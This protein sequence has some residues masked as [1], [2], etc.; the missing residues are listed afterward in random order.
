[1][2]VIISV[3][4]LSLMIS[5]IGGA[6]HLGIRA[7]ERDSSITDRYQ[8]HRILVDQLSQE[9]RSAYLNE[10]NRNIVFQGTS[11]EV[12]FF[13]TTAGLDG[14][15]SP[16]GIRA[17]AYTAKEGEGLLV[18][19]GQ[20]GLPPG[21]ESFTKGT[22]MLLSKTVQEIAFRYLDRESSRGTWNSSWD[23]GAKRRLPAAVEFTLHYEGED[24]AERPVTVSLP[25]N[26]TLRRSVSSGAQLFGG[27]G[28]QANN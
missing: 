7:W 6:M 14:A 1:M 5:I 22:E 12:K 4:I 11:D 23:S 24:E 21:E 8:S 18:H 20:A 28:G 3:A 25:V 19:V 27:Q 15:L 17:I 2:E 16:M 10:R 9:L 13:T 26:V